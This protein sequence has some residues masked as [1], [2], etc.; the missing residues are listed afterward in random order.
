MGLFWRSSLH[1]RAVGCFCRGTLMFDRALIRL[2]LRKRFLPLGLHRGILNSSYILILLIHTKHKDNK[3]KSWTDLTSSFPWRRTNTLGRQDKKRVT[4]SRTTAH[5]SWMVRCF[6]RSL[7]GFGQKHEHIV[8]VPI[9][10]LFLFCFLLWDYWCWAG[11]FWHFQ[12]VKP[13]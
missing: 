10:T 13:G 4:N 3:M 9:S 11:S 2:C 5:K 7:R 1:V 8:H 12:P 6:H